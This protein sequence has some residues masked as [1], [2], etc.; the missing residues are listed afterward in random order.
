MGIIDRYLLRKFLQTFLICFVSLFGLYVLIE[1]STNLDN[2]VRGGEKFGEVLQFVAQYYSFRAVW[3]F[4][5]VSGFL[6]LIS[7]MFT[8]AWIQRHNEMI[9]L[10][11]A[12]V[13]RLRVLVPIILAV[14]VISL[15]SVVNR[16]LLIP[17]FREELSRR[18]QDPVGDQPQSLEKRY[19]FRTEVYFDGKNTYA[20]QKRI[21]L[22]DFRLPLRLSGY[23]KKL[24]A[25]SAYYRPAEGDRP[26]GYLFDGVKEPKNLDGRASLLLEGRPV[27]LTPHDYPHWLKPDQCFLVSDL[28]FD[29]L[30]GGTTFKQLSSTAEL[31]RGLRN[32]SADFG[33]D[34]RTTVHARIVQPLLDI[35]LLFL[36]LPLVVGRESRN[37]FIAMG[38]C[39]GL[40]VAFMLVVFASQQMGSI[41]FWPFTPAFAAWFPLMIFAPLAAGL[42]ELLWR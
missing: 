8:V 40:N 1:L 23:G 6:A 34:V 38:L 9:A 30:A 32:P 24:S 35:T 11:A 15:L 5:R 26:S 33:A 39:M 42:A 28:T 7:A 20:R 12:G 21:E 29:Q 27:L 36:G 4:D 14:A 13:S 18:P 16:E 10:M 41:S 37:V 25:E 17:R 3:F 19:D 2:F 31:I 22:P